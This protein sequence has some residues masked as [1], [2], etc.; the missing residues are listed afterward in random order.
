MDMVFDV[1]DDQGALLRRRTIDREL[2]EWV[3][4]ASYPG[5]VPDDLFA[6]VV[7]EEKPL[8]KY[9]CDSPANTLLSMLYFRDTSQQLGPVLEKQAAQKLVQAC[10]WYGFAPPDDLL[11][12][13]DINGTALA[14]YSR[15]P[16]AAIQKVLDKGLGLRAIKTG[17]A[18]PSTLP[19]SDEES[20]VRELED[21]TQPTTATEPKGDPAAGENLTSKATKGPEKVGFA[22]FVREKQ[23]KEQGWAAEHPVATGFLGGWAGG[24]IGGAVSGSVIRHSIEQGMS[25]KEKERVRKHLSFSGRHPVFTGAA[26]G[27]LGGFGGLASGAA[28]SHSYRRAIEKSKHGSYADPIRRKYPLDSFDDV[29]EANRYFE[30]YASEFDPQTRR[31]MATSIYKRSFELGVPIGKRVDEESLSKLASGDA[32]RGHLFARS[33]FYG[34]TTEAGRM[35]QGLMSKV[36]SLHPQVMME[37]VAQLDAHFG[38]IDFWDTHLPNPQDIVFEKTA[39]D[40]KSPADYSYDFGTWR[41]SGTDLVRLARHSK[42]VDA[43][44]GRDF[45]EQFR[46]DPTG[47]FEHLPRPEKEVLGRMAHD[48]DS[49]GLNRPS[50]N[51]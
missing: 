39:Q 18:A 29:V 32:V 46:G 40:S 45:A 17:Q 20:P 8:R 3:K 50:L 16:K 26:A 30:K 24:P 38:G 35:F 33:T 27:V 12:K 19:P 25:E 14:P 47:F 43:R 22:A 37:V 4:E 10:G 1:Y 31:M 2:P 21:E 44:F 9:A 28:T 6:L 49:P 51:Q 5:D 42:H 23:A 34:T 41:V 11:K 15:Q 48:L 36:G 7:G 13:A